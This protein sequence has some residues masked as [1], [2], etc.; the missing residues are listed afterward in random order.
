MPSSPYWPG[1]MSAQASPNAR[2]FLL[3]AAEPWVIAASQRYQCRTR[4]EIAERVNLF[5]KV[6]LVVDLHPRE[7]RRFQDRQKTLQI[8]SGK[9]LPWVRQRGQPTHL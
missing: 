6:V 7:A 3:G 5:R 1:K 2:L 4:G 8:A 9:Q